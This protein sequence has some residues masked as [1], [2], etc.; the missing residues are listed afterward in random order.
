MTTGTGGDEAPAPAPAPRECEG[1]GAPA[2]VHYL[3]GKWRRAPMCGSC[4]DEAQRIAIRQDM[5]ATIGQAM[6][7]AQYPGLTRARAA[8]MHRDLT[9]APC[10]ARLAYCDPSRPSWA[11][12][13]GSHV[14]PV[15]EHVLYWHRLALARAC[16]AMQSD[17][18]A[19]LPTAR[20]VRERVLFNSR[21]PG[22]DGGA[23]HEL[24]LLIVT[25]AGT[26][27]ATEYVVGEWAEIVSHRVSEGLP[28]VT[29]GFEPIDQIDA[30]HYTPDVIG[31]IRY[32]MRGGNSTM[33]EEAS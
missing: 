6:G 5:A 28:T 16:M 26:A 25:E 13:Y 17:P 9:T 2:P 1:C 7:Q 31:R 11:H 23:L 4:A 14:A 27:Q 19:R 20:V 3:A 30:C 8:S 24:D 33:I 21:R 32:A 15:L 22:G 29:C 18:T 10:L 12:L